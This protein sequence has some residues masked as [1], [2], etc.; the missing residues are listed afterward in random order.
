M[1]LKKALC[2]L[3][4]ANLIAGSCIVP[5]AA[6]ADEPS[7][8]PQVIYGDA[9][10][11][12]IVDVSDAVLIAKFASADSTAKITDAG[13]INADVDLNEVVD[14]DDLTQVLEFIVHLRKALGPQTVN[15]QYQSVN[16]LDG[17]TPNTIEGKKVDD[18]F[19]LS[20]LNFSSELF[21][22]CA[23]A[24][25]E[26]PNLL[27]SPLS[28]TQ[29]LA[30]T[31]NGAKGET[32]KQMEQ[33][34]GGTLEMNALNEYYYDY[35]SNLASSEKASLDLANSIWI[36]DDESVI[37]V[38]QAFLQTTADYYDSAV[39]RAAFDEGTLNDINAW[40]SDNTHGMIPHML[41]Q[42][43]PGNVMFLINALA[44]DAKWSEPLEPLDRK[45]NFYVQADMVKPVDMMKGTA[46]AYISDK[47]SAGFLKYYEGG[48]YAFAAILPDAEQAVTISDYIGMMS[49]ESLKALLD[50]R[51]KTE[52]QVYVPKFSYDYDIVLNETLSKM[53]MELPFLPAADFTGLDSL[54][55]T[56]IDYV[57]HKTFIAVDELGTKAG[58]ATVVSMRK[59]SMPQTIIRLDCPFIYMILDMHT[60]LP[61]FMGVLNDPAPDIQ[62][63]K[64]ANYVS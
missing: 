31:A 56:Y 16:L 12:G 30:M 6:A 11:S 24:E 17:I 52:V 45:A 10:E 8:S 27:I 22:N 14:S 28:V 63:G 51:K 15:P 49:G 48:D 26:K 32:K 13:K 64:V 25:Q 43:D 57:L 62:A 47:Y 50:S 1:K 7:A 9:D 55:G 2:I 53:G 20:Q 40:I 18:A 34:L 3:A 61:V 37:K 59:N 29:A 5:S 36:L 39:F 38:P 46:D 35:T 21:R 23:F 58:A 60:N 19:V 41:D 42:I 54:G 4:A 44:F 33:V